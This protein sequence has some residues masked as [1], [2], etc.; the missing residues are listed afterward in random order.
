MREG[1]A[2]TSLSSVAADSD[3]HDER[4]KPAAP[5]LRE[6]I[7]QKLATVRWRALITTCVILVDYFLLN[8]SISLIGVFYPAE[9]SNKTLKYKYN[10]IIMTNTS[11]ATG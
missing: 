11:V 10:N 1:E 4:S 3:I 2:I 6:R 5:T 8:A 7:C 9:V